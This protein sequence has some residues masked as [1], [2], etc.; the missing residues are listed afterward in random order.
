MF[1]LDL[2]LGNVVLCFL[3][4][5]QFSWAGQGNKLNIIAM[6]HGNTS[7]MGVITLGELWSLLKV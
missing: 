3:T 6:K 1:L 7:F 5:V 2:Q 4:L